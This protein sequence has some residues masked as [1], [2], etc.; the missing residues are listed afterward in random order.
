MIC[1]LR[2]LEGY[3]RWW[4]LRWLAEASLSI[5]PPSGIGMSAVPCC[6]CTAQDHGT[7][8][9]H[10]GTLKDPEGDSLGDRQ[11]KT[12]SPVML[13]IAEVNLLFGS[14]HLHYRLSGLIGKEFIKNQKAGQLCDI[15]GHLYLQCKAMGTSGCQ[16]SKNSCC[17]T[18]IWKADFLSWFYFS[19]WSAT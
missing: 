19:F 11:W 6:S 15:K 4:A 5:H 9:C 1:L 8:L 2:R 13:S 10:L 17:S 12:N 14:L 16:T 3:S 7:Q 18:E